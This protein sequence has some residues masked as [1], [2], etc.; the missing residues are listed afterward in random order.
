MKTKERIV[1]ERGVSSISFIWLY[2]TDFFIFNIAYFL[3]NFL[4]R[5][6]FNLTGNYTMLL[7]LF[8]ICW[9]VASFTAKKFEEESYLTFKNGL[10][11][12]GRSSLYMLYCIAF[13]VVFLGVPGFS[14]VQLF[15]T[16]LAT[17]F[18]ESLV[19]FVY[20]KSQKREGYEYRNVK[21]DSPKVAATT[22]PFSYVLFGMDFLLLILSLITVN[23][24]KRGHLAFPESY[25]MLFI[26]ILGLW[27]TV[28]L[29]TDK[30]RSNSIKNYTLALAQWLK[31][32]A[33]MLAL[34]AVAVFG[35]RLFYI[36]RF[37]S[38]GTVLMLLLFE[39]A[40]LRIYFL[41]KREEKKA[42]DIES[43][44]TVKKILGQKSLNLDVDVETIRENL[45]EPVRGKLEE[46][47]KSIDHKLFEFIDEHVDLGNILC[48]ETT[49]D[50]SRKVFSLTA[51]QV[52]IRL[53][54]NL[55]KI[56]DIRRINQYLLD[57]HQV[58]LPGGY[59]IGRAHTIVTH[60]EWIY[61]KY[62]RYIVKYVYMV[63]FCFNRVI[64]KLPFLNKIYFA[65]TNGKDRVISRAELLGR[66]HFCGFEIV[67]EKNIDK[68]LCVIA[69]KVKSP[70][71]DV[72]PTYGPL[73][74]LKRVGYNNNIIKTYKLRTMHPYSEYLQQY[75]FENF[76]GT[77]DGD[78]F[79]N[80]FRITGWGKICRKFWIDELPMLMN[81]L[82]GDLKIVGVRPLSQ[83]KFSMYSE[84]NQ[85]LRVTVK[86]GLVPPFYAD[87]PK[88]FEGLQESEAK[89]I[90]LYHKNPIATDIR[91]FFVVMWNIFVKKARSK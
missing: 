42:D 29:I 58:L 84:E 34:V 11:C 56:N 62:P 78:G 67:A 25:E 73:V 89:Y 82:K 26:M 76:G 7:F 52:P 91:Y 85:K 1:E 61:D 90:K 6:T 48:L 86:P 17:F 65:L 30:F 57:I 3:C 35:L 45:F 28:S 44:E 64:P 54:L 19:W 66:L 81:W 72:S 43:I 16:C 71:L 32:G 31:A 41:W 10:R 20:Y 27:F 68:R 83:H 38:F 15:S 59:F 53:M 40:A 60:K 39:A 33:I 37:Q 80:D 9:F 77:V 79:Q 50:T 22:S 55:R 18:I 13:A 21:S 87:L 24:I 63:D 74:E 8:Y 69:R 14:R 47:L 23:Y 12:F 5:G 4:K 75:I 2:V 88:D 70:S 51:D 49:A 36:S 46:K